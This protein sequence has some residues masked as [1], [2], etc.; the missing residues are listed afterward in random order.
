MISYYALKSHLHIRFSVFL[1]VIKKKKILFRVAQKE[2]ATLYTCLG[3]KK[4]KNKTF[5]FLLMHEVAKFVR[6]QI[7]IQPNIN[8]KSPCTF[9]LWPRGGRCPW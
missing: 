9:L 6:P 8:K 4:K 1:S 2:L 7:S 5:S 3:F